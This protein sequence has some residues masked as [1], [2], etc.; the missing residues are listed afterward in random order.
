MRISEIVKGFKGKRIVVFGDL[1]ADCYV[2]GDI[3]RVSR[4]APVLI[5][6]QSGEIIIP[7]S[8]GNTVMNIKALGG[9]PVPVG[10]LGKD[11]S[12]DKL[13]D[14]FSSNDIDTSFILRDAALETVTKSRI[15]AGVHNVAKQQVVRIDSGRGYFDGSRSNIRKMLLSALKSADGYIISDYAGGT[16]DPETAHGEKCGITL[17]DSRYRLTS[18]TGV[19]SATPNESEAEEAVGYSIDT[20]ECLDKAGFELLAKIKAEA[21]VI[22]R[23]KRGMSV[24]RK[25]LCRVDIP[26]FGS[27]DI[28][29]VT[30]AGDTVISAYCLALTAGTGH[31]GAAKLA[32]I[33]GGLVVMKKGTAVVTS[34]EIVSMSNNSDMGDD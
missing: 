9:E 11:S 27:E 14:I 21:V 28:A 6:R 25:G 26:I 29:D 32:N 1:V 7:G 8:A 5:I 2:F 17:V 30:G 18:F 22:T 13:S 4:E 15:L 24:F 34:D 31:L 12:G 33:A 19:T 20:D 23:G 16:V 10:F 3:E